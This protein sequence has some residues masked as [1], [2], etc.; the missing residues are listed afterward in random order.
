MDRKAD[1][2]GWGRTNI[3]HERLQGLIDRSNALKMARLLI[4]TMLVFIICLVGITMWQRGQIH[5]Y[6][7]EIGRLQAEKEKRPLAP[8]NMR[9]IEIQP[10]MG[11][12]EV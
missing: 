7:Q 4:V 5:I 12:G 8:K 11:K 3:T 2:E 9:P 6:Q 1:R 10:C